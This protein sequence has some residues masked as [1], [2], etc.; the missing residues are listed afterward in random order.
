MSIVPRRKNELFRHSI[1]ML[2][3]IVASGCPQFE[4]D[5]PDRSGCQLREGRPLL[6]PGQFRGT[7]RTVAGPGGRLTRQGARYGG[8]LRA[9]SSW[10]GVVG[11]G[12]PRVVVGDGQPFALEGANSL[13]GLPVLEIIESSDL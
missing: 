12:T 13:T 3:R 11:L 1:A 2:G 7:P 9:T 4:E 8:L 6:A 5:G 10:E